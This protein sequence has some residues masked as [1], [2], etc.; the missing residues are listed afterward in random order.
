MGRYEDVFRRSLS[1][2]AGFWGE[3]ARG[4]DWYTEPETIL[5]DSNPPFYR[6]FRGG[7]LNTCHNALDRHISNGR[8]GQIALIYDSPVT[9]TKETFTY[10][11]LRYETAKFAGVLSKLGIRKGDRVD[12]VRG[13]ARRRP[14]CPRGASSY[15]SSERPRLTAWSRAFAWRASRSRSEAISESRAASSSRCRMTSVSCCSS[16][17]IRR[18]AVIVMPSSAM[19]AT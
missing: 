6:W 2:P 14:G 8:A 5:D 3:A 7:T 12:P 10:R 19:V 11:E 1:D 13:Q 4:V 18:M 9:G 15:S 17:M 16:S